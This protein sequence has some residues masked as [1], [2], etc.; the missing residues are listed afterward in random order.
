MTIAKPRIGFLGTGWIG[1]HRMEAIL[2]TGLVEAVA[3]ADP[4]PEMA[5]EASTLAPLYVL[6]GLSVQQGEIVAPMTAYGPDDSHASGPSVPITV[7]WHWDGHG[8]VRVPS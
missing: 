1:R 3:L 7:R 8:F 4:S 2:A 6:V 5:A